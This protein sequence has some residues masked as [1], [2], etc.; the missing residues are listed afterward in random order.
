PRG[1]RVAAGRVGAPAA[2]VRMVYRVPR[3]AARLRAHAHVTLAAGLADRDVLVLGVADDPDGR[4]ALGADHPH[5]AA[6][7]AQRGHALV[8]RHELRAR[9]GGAHHLRAAAGLELDVVDRGA[10]R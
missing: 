3:R 6:G 2:A 5:L 9:A 1:H 10:D 8:L 4:A 7:Q